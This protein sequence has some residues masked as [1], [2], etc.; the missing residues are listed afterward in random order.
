MKEKGLETFITGILG[1]VQSEANLFFSLSKKSK[2]WPDQYNLQSYT[3]TNDSHLLGQVLPVWGLGVKE[4]CEWCVSSVSNLNS[5]QQIVRWEY[6]LGGGDGVMKTGTPHQSFIN[7]CTFLCWATSGCDPRWGLPRRTLAL[8][9]RPMKHMLWPEALINR[10]YIFPGE[11][12]AWVS[13]RSTPGGLRCKESGPFTASRTLW[14]DA[15]HT[16]ATLRYPICPHWDPI[17]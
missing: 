10:I 11:G 14:K 1:Y 6:H 5:Y 7:Q 17:Q 16:W 2:C 3:S 13:S 15:G 4:E 12:P 8:T 9:S